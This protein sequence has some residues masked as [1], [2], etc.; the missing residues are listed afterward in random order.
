MLVCLCI[1]TSSH[2]HSASNCVTPPCRLLLGLLPQQTHSRG[3]SRRRPQATTQAASQMVC[4]LLNTT[5][6]SNPNPAQPHLLPCV[7]CLVCL[8]AMARNWCTS[9]A[10]RNG[11]LSAHRPSV[12]SLR[13]HTRRCF[14]RKRL[15]IVL[16]WAGL[17]A[18][19]QH[20]HGCAS[21]SVC[22]SGFFPD[23]QQCLL[24]TR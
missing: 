1:R 21:T 10:L 15:R 22:R 14:V 4:S 13:L 11:I 17:R 8:S 12:A 19:T 9:N 6:M 5:H 20:S 16:L 18:D 7:C 2:H 3:R 23:E 24:Q